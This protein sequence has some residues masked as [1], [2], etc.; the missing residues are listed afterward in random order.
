[1]HFFYPEILFY[2]KI[3]KIVPLL[4]RQVMLKIAL[5]DDDVQ[6]L[7]RLKNLLRRYQEERQSAIKYVAFTNAIELLQELHRDRYDVLLLD[8]LMPGFNGMEAAHEIREFDN[9]I[10]IIFLTSSPEFAV[11]SYAVGAYYY[12][13][14]PCTAEKLFSVLDRFFWDSQ[15]EEAALHIKTA[16]GM[17]RIPYSRLEFLEVINK[18][19]YF[20]L[21]DGSVREISGS[22]SDF[23]EELLGREEFIKVHRS[24]IVNMGC[25]QELNPQELIT[26]AKQSAP[27][28]R[29]LY[30]K[31]KEA[32]MKY[33]FAEKGVR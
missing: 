23:E 5:C 4:R 22:L 10:K 21:T 28:S 24:C 11:E 15:K 3:N 13:L 18:R 9:R 33:M 29:L 7:S 16:S 19:L 20:H 2:G 6:E 17:L 12:L 26:N 32:Y 8:I 14:K 27:V 30:P 1:M 31:I 25:I